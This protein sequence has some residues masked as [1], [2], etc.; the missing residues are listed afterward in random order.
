M[1]SVVSVDLLSQSLLPAIVDLAEDGKWRVRLAI[2]E[3]IPILA[4][5][6]GREYFGDKLSALCMAWLDDGVHSIR[7][8]AT[9]NLMQLTELFG[10]EWAVELIIP[11]IGRMQ[12]HQNYLH[13]TTA[14]YVLQVVVRCLSLTAINKKVLPI[15][16][17]MAADPVPNIRFITAKTIQIVYMSSSSLKASNS[18]TS[19]YA[20]TAEELSSVLSKLLQDPDRDVKFYAALAMKVASKASSP[21][22]ALKIVGKT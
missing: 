9:E 21:V 10:E 1:N 2:I 5:H 18:N 8:A 12:M 17:L 22:S 14:L 7:R 3:L 15:I 16:I 20:A 6:L 11:R 19:L 4:K 13:R